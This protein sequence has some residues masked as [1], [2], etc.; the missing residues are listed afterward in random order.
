MKLTPAS[1]AMVLVAVAFV[2]FAVFGCARALSAPCQYHKGNAKK[3]CQRAQM[4]WPPNP[5]EAEAR[6]R[7]NRIGG[8][9]TWEK[10][11][12]IAICETGKNPRHYIAADGTPLGSYIGAFGMYARTFA[13]GSRRTGYRG[14]TY[15]EQ[16]LIAV[17]SWPITS[18]WQGWG[19]RGA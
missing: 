2:V 9:G 16:A 13:Y 14:R 11:E 7:L 19:C 18:Q 5:T 15:A 17:A 10:A 1:L 12:R 3:T 6:V 8:K 4:E